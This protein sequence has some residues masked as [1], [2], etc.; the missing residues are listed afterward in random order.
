MTHAED[1][2]DVS[3]GITQSVVALS[4]SIQQAV[5]LG[6]SRATIAQEVGVTQVTLRNLCRDLGIDLPR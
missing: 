1:V 6:L 3:H 2:I 5:I 4:A